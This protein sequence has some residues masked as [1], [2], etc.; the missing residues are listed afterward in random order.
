MMAGN[1]AKSSSQTISDVRNVSK[2]LDYI[3][4]VLGV[5]GPI[6]PFPELE[7]QLARS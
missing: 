6:L 7:H 3:A 2:V 1:M 4:P 5:N